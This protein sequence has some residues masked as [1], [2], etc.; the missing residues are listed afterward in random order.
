M[1]YAQCL[2]LACSSL[3][4]AQCLEGQCPDRLSSEG[5]AEEGSLVQLRR[6]TGAGAPNLNPTDPDLPLLV[7]GTAVTSFHNVTA[8]VYE[9]A[10]RVLGYQ[11]QIVNQ[12]N[13]ANMYPMFVGHGGLRAGCRDDGCSEHCEEQGLGNKSP[14]IDFSVDANIPINHDTY[15][16]AFQDEFDVIGTAYDPF[17]IGLFTPRYSKFRT[18]TE[19]AASSTVQKEIVGFKN[20]VEFDCATFFCPVCGTG[21]VDY[22]VKPPL[23]TAGFSYEPVRCDEFEEHVE[24]MLREKIEFIAFMFTP[25]AWTARFPELVEMDLQNYSYQIIPVSGKALLRKASAHKF[26]NKARAVLQGLFIGAEGVKQMDGWAHGFNNDPP[27][28]LC[29]YQSF[30]TACAEEAADKWIKQNQN[31]NTLGVKGTW[32]SNF[33]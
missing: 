26:S 4:S 2:L 33:W 10:L 11:V 21:D 6:H 24:G 18:L 20:G 19:A 14:C 1:R 25:S 23:G 12:Y 8:W 22:I 13:H 9:R 28:P 15:L 32:P 5:D 27:G 17:S 16:E 3:V 29:D 7:I 31:Y 30:N